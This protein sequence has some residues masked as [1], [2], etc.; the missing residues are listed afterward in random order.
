MK[1]MMHTILA[2]MVAALLVVPAAAR[3]ISANEAG[4]AAAAWVRRDRAPLGA[5]IR[6]SD[7]AEV[8]TQKEGDT[9]LFHVVRMT[10]GGVVVTSAESG[11][12]P[13]VAF[14]DG[15]DIQETQGNPLWEILSADMSTRLARV[16]AVREGSLTGLTRLT[17][18]KDGGVFQTRIL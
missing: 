1:N 11:V 9:P 15:G 4:R 3:E 13:V 8:R 6:S 7:V 14:L 17:G 5:A 10:G 12:T 16:R 18:L 2:A